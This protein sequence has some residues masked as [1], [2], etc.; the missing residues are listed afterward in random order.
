MIASMTAFAQLSR[1]SS[2]GTLIWTLRSVNH[3]YLEITP[4]LPDELRGLEPALREAIKARLQ[5][6]KVEV[7]LQHRSDARQRQARLQ[8]NS[9]LVDHL[10][11]LAS[12]VQQRQGVMAGPTPLDALR[13]LQWPGVI[14][15]QHPDQASLAPLAMALLDEALQAFEAARQQEGAA[16]A[17]MIEQRLQGVEQQLAEMAKHRDSL[18]TVLDQRLRD[19]LASLDVTVDPGRMEQELALQLQKLDVDEELDRLQVHVDEVRRILAAGGASGRRLD[20]LM[21]ELNR[22]ANTLGSKASTLAVSQ[23]AVEL[24]VLIEQMREQVQNIE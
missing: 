1:D 9:E 8:L 13:L 24:K 4:R 5:R 15:E 19:R 10:L 7:Q 3:R 17:E 16:M 2:Y 18:R 14:E 23:A 12:E 22:E 6:G 11:D 20:F 21:Q